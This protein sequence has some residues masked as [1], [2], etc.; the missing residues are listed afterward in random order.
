VVNEALDDVRPYWAHDIEILWKQSRRQNGTFGGPCYN[1]AVRFQIV[2][3]GKG[4][5]W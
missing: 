3:A 4:S 2:P 1:M 5:S